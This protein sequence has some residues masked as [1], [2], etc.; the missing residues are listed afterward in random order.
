[1]NPP[2][3]EKAGH[4]VVSPIILLAS[5]G[6]SFGGTCYQHGGESHELRNSLLT[7]AIEKRADEAGLNDLRNKV[8]KTDNIEVR[9]WIE[10]ASE[11]D[12]AE[13]YVLTRDSNS[14]SGVHL[15]APK[16]GVTT[17]R[18][19]S[20]GATIILKPS[21]RDEDVKVEPLN[22]WDFL[23]NSLSTAGLLTL[24]DESRF[25]L[26]P[27][28]RTGAG[29]IYVVEIKTHREYR[30]YRYTNPEHYDLPE[31]K[32]MAR[33]IRILRDEFSKDQQD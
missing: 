26:K 21:S 6:L 19:V 9:I 1:M 33:T 12:V 20:G 23:W 24:P 13:G 14:W 4:S 7:P 30:S 3:K 31:T 10:P 32:A 8:L 2:P 5:F 28:K 29:N 25:D 16:P 27:D 11:I 15:P 17:M 18:G 22:G